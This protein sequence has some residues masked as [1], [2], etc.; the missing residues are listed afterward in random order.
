MRL[1]INDMKN[2]NKQKKRERETFF[3][4]CCKIECQYFGGN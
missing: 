3:L 1:Y 4:N 2:A